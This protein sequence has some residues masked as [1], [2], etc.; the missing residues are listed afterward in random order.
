MRAATVLRD[1]MAAI[2]EHR[3]D[4]LVRHLHPDFSCRY[5]H[6]GETFDR[7]AWIRLNAEYPG[8]DRLRVEEIV[9]G[10]GTAACRSHVTSRGEDGIAHFAC[11]TFVRLED[12]LI[13][14]MTEVW[15][16]VAQPAPPG[17]RPD[18]AALRLASL[19]QGPGQGPGGALAQGPEQPGR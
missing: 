14:E 3:W 13:R 6:T 1:L 4:D 19:A 12:G 18:T 10:D 9:G 5:P 2:D 15:T 11:A 17:T 7:E 8:F 16:D